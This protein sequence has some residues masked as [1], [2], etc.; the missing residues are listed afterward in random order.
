MKKRTL[1]FYFLSAAALYA[2]TF[3]VN[4]PVPQE[5]RVAEAYGAILNLGRPA[6]QAEVSAATRDWVINQVQDYE[7]RKNMQ[8]F[9]P[10]PLPIVT[11]TP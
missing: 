3:C 10:T 2:G 11:A 8:I 6:T 1:L 7:R 9:T 4:I 5:T